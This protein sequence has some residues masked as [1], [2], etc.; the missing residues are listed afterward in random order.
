M[1]FQIIAEI[2]INYADG[3]DHSIDK[4]L[5]FLGPT[6]EILIKYEHN[7]LLKTENSSILGNS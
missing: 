5:E 1:S 4:I 7:V 6:W 3:S 2:G